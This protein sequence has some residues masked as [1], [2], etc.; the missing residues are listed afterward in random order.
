MAQTPAHIIE[1]K[2]GSA[3]FAAAVGV[4]PSHARVWKH[5]NQFPRRYW[6]EIGAAYPDLDT[7]ALLAAERAA[8]RKKAA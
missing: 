1:D 7:V 2:G 6:P 3:A 4:T 5:R 8:K